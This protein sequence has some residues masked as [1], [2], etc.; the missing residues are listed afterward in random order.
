MKWEAPPDKGPRS[1][2]WSKIFAELKANPDRW[3]NLYN[4]K[5]R[6]AHSLAGRLRKQYGEGYKITSQTVGDGDA[7]VWAKYLKVEE[8]EDYIYTEFD[9]VIEADGGGAGLE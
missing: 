7:G 2:K 6:N 3:A 9:R 5:T 4:G 1:T 8:D